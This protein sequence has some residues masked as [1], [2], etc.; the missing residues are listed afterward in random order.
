MIETL[1]HCIAIVPTRPV[2]FEFP[3]KY[4]DTGSDGDRLWDD[5]MPSKQVSPRHGR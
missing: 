2:T 5:L 3:T 1:M 4:E